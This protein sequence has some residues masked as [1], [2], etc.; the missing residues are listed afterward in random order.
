MEDD[1]SCS[2]TSTQSVSLSDNSAGTIKSTTSASVCDSGKVVLKAVA[3]GSGTINWRATPTGASIGTGATFTT[4]LIKK[5]TTY[6]VNITDGTCSSSP[7]AVPA[8]V[9]K[10][11]SISLTSNAICGEGLVPLTAT[12]DMGKITWYADSLTTDTLSTKFNFSPNVK[13]TTK[14]FVQADNAGC[15][16]VGR[17]SVI[18]TIKPIPTV[19]N[20]IA[21]SRC[22]NGSV[23]ISA[24]ASAGTIRWYNVATGGSNLASTSTD[25]YTTPSNNTTTKTYYAEAFLG[26]CASAS[27]TAVVATIH[28]IPIFK[29][30]FTNPSKCAVADGTITLIGLVPQTNYEVAFQPNTFTTLTSNSAGN[31]IQK[32]LLAGSY[33]IQ[34]KTDKSCTA[35]DTTLALID[36]N[37]PTINAGEDKQVCAGDNVTLTASNPNGATI[38]WN[39]AVTNGLLFAATTTAKYV[40]TANLGGCIASD[41]V[42]VKV[43]RIRRSHLILCQTKT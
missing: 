30:T 29:T 22:G 40:V 36:P 3:T 24:K 17:K 19:T 27:R 39:N 38:T 13:L 42:V 15:K 28:P 20:P 14:Y 4:P 34:L 12:A 26:N 31:I 37:A 21:A 35:T 8:T 41:E 11:P 16:S 7:I 2:S 5:T 43:K 9:N 23:T 25:S 18:A 6:Y 1:K 10:T 33:T 32:D